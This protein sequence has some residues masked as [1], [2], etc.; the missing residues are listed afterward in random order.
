MEIPIARNMNINGEILTK[1][2][3][4]RMPF[5]KYA[6]SLL[7]EIPEEYF[8]WFRN[9]GFPKGELGAF[10]AMMLEMKTNGLERLLDPLIKSGN[11]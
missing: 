1:L 3:N 5:G 10:M 6:D 4:Y 9:K 2:A 11:H 7:R 8:L